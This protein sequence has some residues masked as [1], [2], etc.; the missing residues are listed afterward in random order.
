[1]ADPG[2]SET[3][4][5]EPW[6]CRIHTPAPPPVCTVQSVTQVKQADLLLTTDNLVGYYPSGTEDRKSAMTKV[7]R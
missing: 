5:D 3:A 7:I 1:M 6:P 2:E 4:D